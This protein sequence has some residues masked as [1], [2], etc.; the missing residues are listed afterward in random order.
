[1]LSAAQILDGDLLAAFVAFSET[2][3]FTQA[4]RRVHL[5]QP[6]LFERI[7]RLSELVGAPLHERTGRVVTLTDA[8]RRL[9]AFGR[10]ALGRGEALA[11]EL[12][13][14][15]ARHAVTLA[16]GEGAFLYLLGP[17]LARF[18]AT[19]DATLHLKTTGAAATVAA[20]Q[21]GEADL[22]FTVLDLVPAGLEGEEVL[23]V[24]LCAA[25]PARHRLAARRAVKLA[26]LAPER[27]VLPPAG[28]LFRDLAARFVSMRGA[29]L[30]APLEADGWPLML[31]FVAS[32]LGVALV[33]GSCVA[34]R[35]VVLRPV[36]ELGSVG[37]RLVWRKGSE[38]SQAALA[39]AE[40]VRR[41]LATRGRG[42]K[43]TGRSGRF[44]AS[45]GLPVR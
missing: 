35:G 5:S 6:A 2:L 12:R 18:D 19:S 22:G 36:P 11:R 14:E 24:P 4:A 37:Y 26:D 45:R 28:R 15:P 31:S 41:G 8:G 30:E 3:S 39:L 25:L 32:G 33:N 7:K 43:P 17:A 16:A 20:V 34:P 44:A 1:M 13:G 40:H 21:G 23:R 10:D 38:R 42:G 27:L 29:E 9:A